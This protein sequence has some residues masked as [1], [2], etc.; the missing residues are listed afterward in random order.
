MS[1]SDSSDEDNYGLTD[2]FNPIKSIKKAAKKGLQRLTQNPDDPVVEAAAMEEQLELHPDL[3]ALGAQASRG[4]TVLGKPIY[5]SLTKVVLLKDK[6]KT[7]TLYAIMQEPEYIESSDC[8]PVTNFLGVDFE[9]KLYG[10]V[11]QKGDEFSM[12]PIGAFLG[13]ES[14]TKNEATDTYETGPRDI[15]LFVYTMTKDGQLVVVADSLYS[16][17]G[18]TSGGILNEISKKLTS[19][20]KNQANKL[21]K[22]TIEKYLKEIA[23]KKNLITNINKTNLARIATDDVQQYGLCELLSPLEQKEN[24]TMMSRQSVVSASTI[25]ELLANFLISSKSN[26]KDYQES[27]APKLEISEKSAE[28]KKIEEETARIKKAVEGY[29][30]H[31]TNQANAKFKADLDLALAAKQ[32]EVVK[33]PPRVQSNASKLRAAR[34]KEIEQI[35]KKRPPSELESGG[36]KTKT[37]HRNRN[38]KSKRHMKNKNHRKTKKHRTK[39][40]RKCK[41]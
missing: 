5:Q 24:L 2:L 15:N 25:G 21:A 38:K 7:T 39:K 12:Y 9:N 3:E 6:A 16:Y 27:L 29:V 11:I 32:E 1:D 4:R 28:S 10:L 30:G 18:S 34:Y 20:D 17:P 36:S 31:K 8:A 19:D 40:S 41:R 23:I 22:E 14:V 13:P 33:K 35:V 26:R 37:K